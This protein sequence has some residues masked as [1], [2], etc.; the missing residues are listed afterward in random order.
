MTP[1]TVPEFDDLPSL[2]DASRPKFTARDILEHETRGIPLTEGEAVR[3]RAY[4]DLFNQGYEWRTNCN[5]DEAS[6][7]RD[8]YKSDGFDVVVRDDAYDTEGYKIK[9]LS[10]ILTRRMLGVD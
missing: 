2:L 8:R 4:A 3:N 5:K 6:E 10:A 1:D 7:C 9:G